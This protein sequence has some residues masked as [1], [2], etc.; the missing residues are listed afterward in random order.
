[1][2]FVCMQM[3]IPHQCLVPAKIRRGAGPLELFVSHL[4]LLGTELMFS[5][6]V[7]TALNHR[8]LLHTSAF[9][10]ADSICSVVLAGIEPLVINY[11]DSI[12]A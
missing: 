8:G 6:S 11:V 9:L 5:A 7:T 2:C 12:M 1:M 10:K 3:Y 4:V